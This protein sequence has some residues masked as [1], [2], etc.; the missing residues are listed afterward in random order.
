[1]ETKTKKSNGPKK[2]IQKGSPGLERNPFS[3]YNIILLIIISLAGSVIYSKTIHFGYTLDDSM[4]TVKNEATQGGVSR[5]GDFF[6]YG[7]MKFYEEIPN[8][9]GIYRPFTL[10]TFGIE[11]DLANGFKPEVGHTINVLLYF[12]LTLSIGVLLL[13]IFSRQNI[14]PHIPL[15]ILLL[16]T[17]HPIHT[18]VVASIKSRDV[19][20]CA[21]FAFL[22]VIVWM[23][24][25]KRK[26]PLITWLAGLLYFISILSKEESITF[27]AIVFFISVFHFQ[28]SF[29]RS[30]L[31]T[32]PF[33]VFT[34]IYLVVRFSILDHDPP[35]YRSVVNNIIFGTSGIESILTNLYI[36]L[37]YIKL[38][39][40]PFPLSWD[41]SYN[42]IP[43]V[44][45]VNLWTVLAIVL[46]VLMIVYIIKFFRSRNILCFGLY[47]YLVTF[48]IFTNII[49]RFI[50]GSTLAERFMLIPSLGFCIFMVHWLYV[51]FM[52]MNLKYSLVILSA[53]II[54]VSGLF[55]VKSYSRSS[56]W[57]NNTTLFQSGIET[58]PN[59]W[60][61]HQKLGR[62]MK[63]RAISLLS[64]KENSPSATDSVSYLF[65]HA[66]TEYKTAVD[67]SESVASI[68]DN[69]SSLGYCYFMVND[70]S[71]A[72]YFFKK[73]LQLDPNNYF[74]LTYLGFISYY[75]KKF[76]S[77]I[78]YYLQ[79]L[80]SKSA[81]LFQTYTNLGNMYLQNKEYKKSIDAL[82]K[83]LDYGASP[84]IYSN[85]AY[86][87]YMLGDYEKVK[88]YKT[89]A[90]KK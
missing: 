80:N 38:L 3:I 57:K 35:E 46:I 77:A 43:V 5:I 60:H 83:A 11:H 37:Y 63:L 30:I 86:D 72:K 55:A 64:G 90:E 19:L 51:L 75:E 16:Y 89:L 36:W 25:E 48:L 40:V 52:K 24:G 29:R 32:L 74:A 12:I 28:N 34:I 81:E 68:P 53:I 45:S 58:A 2:L 1:M 41:Y 23:E 22:S 15:L 69:F 7:S 17:V 73:T 33:F 88:Y 18:E 26:N 4:Y 71:N 47:F 65:T 85:L 13:R 10:L 70:T 82:M 9:S 59:S 31:K 39:I 62:D 67:I 49:P 76:D 21:T 50:I 8:N 6:K 42:Q 20:L 44:S 66:I 14:P 61:T 78:V 27:L 84:S 56:V 87:Y 79:S 54:S